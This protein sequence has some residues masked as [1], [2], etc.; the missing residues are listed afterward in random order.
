VQNISV[1]VSVLRLIPL[2]QQ[3]GMANSA[4]SEMEYSDVSF[5]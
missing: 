5:D 4:E 2:T 1:K 3:I